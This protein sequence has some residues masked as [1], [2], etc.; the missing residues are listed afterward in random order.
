MSGSRENLLEWLE[1][2]KR[3]GDKYLI[4]VSDNWDYEYFPVF[5]KDRELARMFLDR[6]QGERHMEVM[7]TYDISADWNA[8]LSLPRSWAIPFKEGAT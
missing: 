3:A 8:Q 1:R 5:A 7:E 4:V 2:G 6:Y